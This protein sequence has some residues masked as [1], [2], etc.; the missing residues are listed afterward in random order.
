[1]RSQ[2]P[3]RRFEL[4][5]MKK[6]EFIFYLKRQKDLIESKLAKASQE[7]LLRNEKVEPLD[8]I[9][10]QLGAIL[11]QALELSTLHTKNSDKKTLGEIK[12]ASL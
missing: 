7:S 1:M 9:A 3:G 8:K 10:E 4:D 12:N 11:F 2:K 5:Q 6:K